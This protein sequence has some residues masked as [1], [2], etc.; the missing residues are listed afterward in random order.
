MNGKK[1]LALTSIM[2]IAVLAVG[3]SIGYYQGQLL[4]VQQDVKYPHIVNLV[5]RRDGAVIYNHTTHNI[6][7]TIGAKYVRNILGFNNETSQE[8]TKWISLSDDTSP[9][10]SWT[11]LPSEFTTGGLARASATMTVINATAYQA[12]ASWTAT[13]SFTIRC[14]GL[15]W[16]GTAGSDGNLFAVATV[17]DANVI[18]GDEV[19]ITWIVNIPAG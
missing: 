11:K 12:Q 8:A 15:H 19:T 1:K 18:S 9:S 4:A 13:A 5:V 3:F 16:S 17:P 10:A 7:T 14:T 6:I 2:L